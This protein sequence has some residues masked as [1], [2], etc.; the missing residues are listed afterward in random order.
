MTSETSGT[1]AYLGLG[2]NAGDRMSNIERA[3]KMLD[4]AEGVTVDKVSDIIETEPWGFAAEEKFL[5]CAVRAVIAADVTPVALLDICKRIERLSG[6]ED[7]PEYDASGGRIYHSRTI[8]V[9]ILLFGDERI[10]SERLTVPHP[11]MA[12]RDFVMVPLRQIVLQDA[13]EAFPE[14]FGAEVFQNNG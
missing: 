6:R 7:G 3:V 14:I 9:D 5:N 13:V 8:D 10:E 12:K 1:V 4:E 2:S 11:L